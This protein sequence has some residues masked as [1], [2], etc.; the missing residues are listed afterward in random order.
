MN[1]R[2]ATNGE[3]E[4]E[5]IPKKTKEE[6]DE[7]QLI[8]LLNKHD[9]IA[10]LDFVSMKRNDNLYRNIYRIIEKKWLFHDIYQMQEM[11]FILNCNGQLS[12]LIEALGDLSLRDSDAGYSCP[13]VPILHCVLLDKGYGDAMVSRVTLHHRLFRREVEDTF[14]ESKIE[15]ITGV[16]KN[17]MAK[18]IPESPERSENV[19]KMINAAFKDLFNII[20]NESIQFLS[21]VNELKGEIRKYGIF[22]VNLL[23]LTASC[24]SRS[25]VIV[26][27]RWCLEERLW[28]SLICMRIPMTLFITRV[29]NYT[30]EKGFRSRYLELAVRFK[31][32]MIQFWKPIEQFIETTCGLSMGIQG[33]IYSFIS[34][35][36]PETEDSDIMK[37]ERANSLIDIAWF[38]IQAFLV[39]KCG[40]KSHPHIFSDSENTEIGEIIYSYLK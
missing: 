14:S 39:D 29:V 6:K 15:A 31:E 40:L 20:R 11:A 9:E 27:I 30:A 21:E 18:Q 1:K 8:S 37:E 19:D 13:L 32:K 17:T 34:G 5:P 24:Q 33:I 23:L 35:E 10:A 22:T 38:H 2:K 28:V 12:L 3:L 26:N 7:L 25:D 4:L 36:P 16:L